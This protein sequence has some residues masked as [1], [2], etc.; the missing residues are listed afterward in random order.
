MYKAVIFISKLWLSKVSTCVELINY[1]TELSG[2]GILN[3]L[4]PLRILLKS[5]MLDFGQTSTLI[6]RTLSRFC[7]PLRGVE[8]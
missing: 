1:K 5:L 2:L 7:S 6:V 8:F 3:I 4:H